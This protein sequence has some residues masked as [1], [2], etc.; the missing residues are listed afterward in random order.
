MN[1]DTNLSTI[2]TQIADSYNDKDYA[3]CLSA[4]MYVQILFCT[5][6]VYFWVLI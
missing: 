6:K 4:A 1:W 5:R 3:K 2:R